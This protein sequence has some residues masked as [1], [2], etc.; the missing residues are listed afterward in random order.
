MPISNS[1][2]TT[3]CH[4]ERSHWIKKN[5]FV[6]VV[7]NFVSQ[8]KARAPWH[9]LLQAPL[10]LNPVLSIYSY[11]YYHKMRLN[12]R[13]KMCLF[14][15]YFKQVRLYSCAVFTHPVYYILL[16]LYIEILRVPCLLFLLVTDKVR[17][18]IEI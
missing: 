10:W 2:I 17:S 12:C 1:L 14:L 8:I 7:F 9:H 13:R 6:S 15:L 4:G 18:P 3:N 16:S 5:L 11:K